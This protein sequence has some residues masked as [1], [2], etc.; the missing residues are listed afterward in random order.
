M[1]K[2]GIYVA[3]YNNPVFLRHCL[4]QIL[5]QSRRPDVLAIHQN[6][7]AESYSWAV[8]D[9]LTSL[10]YGRTE[11]VYL[12]MSHSMAMPTFF[13]WPLQALLDLGCDL[14]IKADHDDIFYDSH[15]A[16]QEKLMFNPQL[17]QPEWDFAMNANSGLLVLMN[18]GGYKYS[19]SVDF[20]IWNPTGAH[21][22]SIIFNRSVAQEF[23]REMG[24]PRNA[25]H[26]LNDDVVLATYVLPK[27]KGIKVHRQPS[28]CFVAHGRN[29]SVSQWSDVPPQ[30]V[31]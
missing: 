2:L 20:G 22:N 24:I 3:S 14:F 17:Q 27:F 16:E 4:L 15:L 25:P 8:K 30:E 29:V 12:H 13:I 19:P 6:A 18:K 9:V 31:L 23:V 28:S 10:E 21:P 1:S 7:D 5:H 11:V 26:G